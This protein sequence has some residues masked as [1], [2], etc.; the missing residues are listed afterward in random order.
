MSTRGKKIRVTPTRISFDINPLPPT[1]WKY[2]GC[3]FVCFMLVI[4][5]TGVIDSGDRPELK[6]SETY[7][8]LRNKSGVDITKLFTIVSSEKFANADLVFYGGS[9]LIQSLVDSAELEGMLRTKSNEN[10]DLIEVGMPTVTP[11]ELLY[12]V[13]RAPHAK[14]QLVVMYVS[15]AFLASTISRSERIFS[16]VFPENVYWFVDRYKM[17]SPYIKQWDRWDRRIV[18]VFR[19]KVVMMFRLLHNRT[20]NLFMQSFYK[21]NLN[22]KEKVFNDAKK[23]GDSAKLFHHGKK[24]RRLLNANL[25]RTGSLNLE[26]V[27]QIQKYLQSQGAKLVLVEAPRLP[28]FESEILGE[29][30]QKYELLLDSL[31]TENAIPYVN[32]NPEMELVNSDFYDS[33][34]LSDTGRVKWSKKLGFEINK[35]LM[36]N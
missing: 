18:T 13:N 17:S 22:S 8:L 27:L 4:V 2:L 34:H 19:T 30:R 26:I 21:Q 28:V 20:Y 33:A 11:L 24:I 10:I 36:S 7:R 9:V 5:G 15:P 31:I 6:E 12:M 1:H 3:A 32:I 23:A 14:G 29:N 16:G 25:M 35:V